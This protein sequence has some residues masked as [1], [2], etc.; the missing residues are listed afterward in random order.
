MAS[1][2]RPDPVIL[3]HVLAQHRELYELVSA[4]RAAL[5]QP[6]TP[7][8][9]GAAHR[10]LGELRTHLRR[11]FDQEERGGFLEEA[12]CRL[13]RLS[14]AVQHILDDHEKLLAEID[15]LLKELA[16]RDHDAETW[17]ATGRHFAAF[18]AHLSVHERNEHA[19]VQDGY[20]EDLGLVD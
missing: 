10:L 19:V 15:G 17:S 9:R 18:A 11:H 2:D 20:N 13:P 3:G 5:D 12:I 6:Y 4:L 16:A 7:E 8:R 14:G 1:I